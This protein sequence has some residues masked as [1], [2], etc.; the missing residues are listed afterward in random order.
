MLNL[1][2]K[3]QDGEQVF[4]EVYGHKVQDLTYGK[5]PGEIAIGIF[6]AIKDNRYLDYPE[7]VQ[8]LLDKHLDMHAVPVI[9]TAEWNPDIIKMADGKSVIAPEQIRE[10]VVIKPMKERYSEKLQGRCIVKAISDEYLCKAD[11]KE[12]SNEFAAH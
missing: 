8:F 2:D 4:F 7:L 12:E 10:G 9:T 1:Q 5:K 3:L 11:K 6:D